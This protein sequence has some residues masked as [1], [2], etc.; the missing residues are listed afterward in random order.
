MEKILRD[1]MVNHLV[2][3]S[4]I[5]KNQHGFVNKKACVTNL[6]ES[7]DMM[8]KA[9]SDKI[10]MGVAFTD[11]SKAFDMVPYK[12]L[13]YKFEAYGFTENLLNWIKSFLHQRF[14]RIVMDD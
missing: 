9:L 12:R 5:S 6:L 13:I 2:E 8:S 7:I 4:L 14:Q 3:H 10:S 11:F 1:T